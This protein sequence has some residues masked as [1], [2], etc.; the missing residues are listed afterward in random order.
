MNSPSGSHRQHPCMRAL[1]VPFK[2]WSEI[3][4]SWESFTHFTDNANQ[5][6]NAPEFET[7]TFLLC[8]PDMSQLEPLF[9]DL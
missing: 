2:P 4:Q 9:P 7:T 6:R 5:D 8:G 1:T 3:L